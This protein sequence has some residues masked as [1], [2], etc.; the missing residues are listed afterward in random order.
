[1][2]MDKLEQLIDTLLTEIESP[3]NQAKKDAPAPHL[4]SYLENLGWVQYFHYDMNDFFDD[5]AFNCEM[6]IKQKLCQFERFDDDTVL[7]NWISASTGMYFEYTL[8]GMEVRHQPDGVPQIQRD[9]PLTKSPDLSL[10]KRH[11][12]YTTGDMP[13]VFRLYDELRAIS[14]DRLGVGFPTWGRGPLDLAIQ[15]RGY[16]QFMN[17][18]RERPQFVHDLMQYIIE[19]RMRWWDAYC[20]HFDTENRG[21]GIGDDWL[22]VP[23][24]SPAVFRDFVFPYYVELEKYHGHIGGIHSCGDKVPFFDLFAELKTMGGYEVNHWTDLE[25]AVDNSAPDK[26]LGIALLNADVLLVTK[27]D[28]EAELRRIK[29]LCEGRSYS[30]SATAIEKIHDDYEYDIR[31]VQTWIE[32]A[33]EVLRSDTV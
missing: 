6:Q 24:T 25:S 19:E 16:E 13:H 26:H 33:K 28:M 30:V 23:F 20:E 22:F 17:D 2:K 4:N 9:H 12:F 21:A 10:L 32:T 31:Q 14:K 27:Q 3:R 5:S 18:T 1:M 7:S 15:L 29:A 8:F 11:D